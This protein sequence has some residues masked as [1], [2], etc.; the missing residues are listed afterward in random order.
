MASGKLS[1]LSKSFTNLF[2][3]K[4]ALAAEKEALEAEKGALASDIL[5]NMENFCGALSTTLDGQDVSKFPDKQPEEVKNFV[6][7]IMRKYC[8]QSLD[9][10]TKE[11]EGAKKALSESKHFSDMSWEY[12]N[13]ISSG[14]TGCNTKVESAAG[15][16]SGRKG[17]K[18]E[19]TVTA[20][21]KDKEHFTNLAQKVMRVPLIFKDMR[22][23]V[24]EYNLKNAQ[25]S[26]KGILAFDE[27]KGRVDEF[28]KGSETAVF[29]ENI[30]E[31]LAG[32]IGEKGGPKKAEG[33]FD[34]IYKAAVDLATIVNGE[35]FAVFNE[36][37]KSNQKKLNDLIEKEEK[38]EKEEKKEKK[39]KK[40]EKK[41]LLSN[42][43]IEN[44]KKY[45]ENLSNMRDYI[46]KGGEYY[47]KFNEKLQKEIDRI[48]E[49]LNGK[50]NECSDEIDSKNIHKDTNGFIKF[51]E[52]IS[53]DL[54]FND[55][56]DKKIVKYHKNM[57]KS[58]SS[59]KNCL[60]KIEVPD[61]VR[62]KK[63]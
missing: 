9:V 41:D 18:A 6:K 13:F 24:L 46:K 37:I 50:V 53:A 17:K 47:Q 2:K 12:K 60:S 61:G 35:N 20:G 30:S 39:E 3:S 63:G 11:I 16:M 59:I 62:S 15:M 19:F 31:S 56:C 27:Y 4:E 10:L 21:K 14:Q 43:I 36:S 58:I 1:K 49:Y 54:T 8:K 51:A 48:Y 26:Q 28:N 32:M 7:C 40:E 52:G 5:N 45:K 57:E 44:V 25:N 55:N 23:A 38:E 42:Q 33:I 34:D 29:S 22:K